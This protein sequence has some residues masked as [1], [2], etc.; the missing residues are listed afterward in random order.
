M[1]MNVGD[2]WGMRK[3]PPAGRGAVGKVRRISKEESRKRRRQKR[4]PAKDVVTIGSRKKVSDGQ[5]TQSYSPF[6][7]D[8]D[9]F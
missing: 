6:R 2:N 9:G 1:G 5:K 3:T 4:A 8:A 7:T